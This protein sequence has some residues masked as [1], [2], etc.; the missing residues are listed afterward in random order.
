M[1]KLIGVLLQIIA[2]LGRV[3]AGVFRS[4]VVTKRSVLRILALI[5]TPSVGIVPAR[6][7]YT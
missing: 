3:Y 5:L 2:T 1:T 4:A 7:N 6:S